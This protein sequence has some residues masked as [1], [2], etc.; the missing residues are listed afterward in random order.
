MRAVMAWALR[1]GHVA[2]EVEAVLARIRRAAFPDSV[3]TLIE[4]GIGTNRTDVVC[5]WEY[6]GGR[7]RRCALSPGICPTL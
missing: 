4:V 5:T 1:L 7:V 6:T 3:S 2:R